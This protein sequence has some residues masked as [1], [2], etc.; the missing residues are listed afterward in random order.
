MGGKNVL[1]FVMFAMAFG[2]AVT[3]L[4]VSDI[5]PTCN[6]DEK[7]L[8]FCGTYLA[9]VKPSPTTDCCNGASEAFKRAMGIPHGQGI[10]DICNCLRVAG[11][12]LNFQEEKL[13]S[14]PDV[15]GIKLSFNMHL[16]I[17]GD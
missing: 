9:N 14:L 5:P 10:R 4:T 15:C 16:C 6:G 7:L 13:V 11:P 3:T 12:T 8:T 1:A 17:Y 2:L